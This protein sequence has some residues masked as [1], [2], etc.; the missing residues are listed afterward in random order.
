MKGG[1]HWWAATTG[2]ELS[3]DGAV[4]Q[5]SRASVA[6]WLWRYAGE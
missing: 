1:P 4:P 3:L 6:A 5:K 2:G